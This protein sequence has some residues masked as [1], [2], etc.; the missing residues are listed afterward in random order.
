EQKISASPAPSLV[1]SELNLIK[2]TCRDFFDE[3]LEMILCDHYNTYLQLRSFFSENLPEAFKLLKF[4]D[5]QTPIFDIFGVEIDIGRA[6]GKRIDLPSGGYLIIEQTEALTSFDVNTG[7]FVGKANAQQ[8]ILTTNLEATVKVV[9][10]LKI[11]NLG[12][13]IV[14]DFI[15]MEDLKDQEKVYNVFLSELEK[16][17]ALTNVLKIS[18][19]GLVQMTRKRTS[20]S[21]G[22]KLLESCPHCEGRG[23]VKS[24][25]TE[26][27]ELLREIIRTSLQTGSKKIRIRVR[28][29][30]K[31]WL[32]LNG[33][34]ALKQISDDYSIEIDF[35]PS[36][37]TIDLIRKQAFEVEYLSSKEPR[38]NW[39]KP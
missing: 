19:L 16:D 27:N 9:E 15:D 5:Q 33:A 3:G 1:Y 22:R 21:L 23:E 13:I 8:T 25:Q 14:I 32:F 6:I 29:D 28:N 36:P 18:E 35:I 10:Q 12:G 11:R 20:E 26:V 2:K 17:K 7:K 24:I 31:D 39:E 30:I 37:L 34:K 4:Y 38:T